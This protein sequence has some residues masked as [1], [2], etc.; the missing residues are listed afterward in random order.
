MDSETLER[1]MLDRALGTLPPDCEALLAAYLA[2]HPESAS[3]CREIEQTVDLA[4]RSFAEKPTK[5]LPAFPADRLWRSGRSFRRWRTAR[6][7]AAVAASI[8]I[9]FGAHVWLSR[10]APPSTSWPDAA[11]V[12]YNGS[13]R[14][15]EESPEGSA[16]WSGRRLYQRASDARRQSPSR[17]IWASPVRL[18][19]IGNES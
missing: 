16:F 11:I 18:P 10:S 7:A 1:L 4:R 14:V 5:S 15:S 8:A 12:A 2:S 19:H 6:I 17:P 9:G 13:V 3:A